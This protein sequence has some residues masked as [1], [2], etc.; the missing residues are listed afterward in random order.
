MQA[1][2]Q[3]WCH[4]EDVEAVDN[5]KRRSLP[6][7][8]SSTSMVVPTRPACIWHSLFEMSSCLVSYFEYGQKPFSILHTGTVQVLQRAE[9]KL[10]RTHGRISACGR[11]SISRTP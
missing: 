1:A 3:R 7:G 8:V 2:S 4:R 10:A 9:A 11:V 5:R 6:R